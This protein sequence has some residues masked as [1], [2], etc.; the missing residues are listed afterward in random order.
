MLA[1]SYFATMSGEDESK[2]GKKKHKVNFEIAT[3]SFSV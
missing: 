2:E 3:K 1:E